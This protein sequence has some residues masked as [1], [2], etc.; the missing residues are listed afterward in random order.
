MRTW[1]QTFAITLIANGTREMAARIILRG[2][3]GNAEC[4]YCF[5]DDT[6]LTVTAGALL[7]L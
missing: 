2:R 7:H 6:R 4:D 3:I 1:I 5:R